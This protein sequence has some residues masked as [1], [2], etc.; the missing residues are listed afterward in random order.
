MTKK[1]RW[2]NVAND[3]NYLSDNGRVLTDIFFETASVT[4]NNVTRTLNWIPSF[5]VID[6]EKKD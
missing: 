5:S 4:T 3:R 2:V 6:W 1:P